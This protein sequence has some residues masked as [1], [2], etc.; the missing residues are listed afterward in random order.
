MTHLQIPRPHNPT[1]SS[2]MVLPTVKLDSPTHTKSRTFGLILEITDGK[3]ILPSDPAQQKN[4]LFLLENRYQK[5]VL[6][7][8]ENRYQG[9]RQQQC[10]SGHPHSHPERAGL[11]LL[12]IRSSGREKARQPPLLQAPRT[13]KKAGCRPTAIRGVNPRASFSSTGELLR[14][15]ATARSRLALRRA[16]ALPEI[17]LSSSER[18]FG[19]PESTVSNRKSLPLFVGRDCIGY[20]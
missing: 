16:D 9:S 3:W 17:G 15:V 10:V 19:A 18:R 1:V 5:N 14:V 6:F 11:V 13:A 20:S 8:L 7:L 4:V 12:I 2:N